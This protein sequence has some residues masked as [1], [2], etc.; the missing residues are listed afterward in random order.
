MK[1]INNQILIILLLIGVFVAFSSC[2]KDPQGG[3]PTINSISLRF[4]P[5]DITA[6]H[7]ADSV[8]TGG[9]IQPGSWIVINGSN[10]DMV[11]LLLV[12]NMV[13]P[14]NPTYVTSNNLIVQIPSDVPTIATDP[15]VPNTLVV[16]T[17]EGSASTSLTMQPPRPQILSIDNE[18]ALPGKTITITG[19]YF[20]YVSS[21]VFPGNKSGTHVSVL[22]PNTLTVTVPDGIPDTGGDIIITTMGGTSITRN[23]A[24]F[25]ETKGIFAGFEQG[26]DNDFADWGYSYGIKEISSSTVNPPVPLINGG[27]MEMTNFDGTNWQTIPA[28]MWW[29]GNFECVIIPD[30]TSVLADIPAST[31]KSNLAFKFEFYSKE[32]WNSGGY[33]IDFND[34]WDYETRMIYWPYFDPDLTKRKP[35]KT[36]D[37]V[38]VTI[39]LT[40]FYST[41]VS[42]LDDLIGS[43]LHWFYWNWDPAGTEGSGIGNM[44]QGK[45]YIGVPVAKFDV[46]FDNL[47]IVRM[48]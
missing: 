7:E 25:H 9:S 11:N 12:N 46:F 42:T 8:I 23:G 35:L 15:D 24:R 22:N 5:S 1:T 18:F 31:S 13:V 29:D 34:N 47:R 26:M 6:G 14:F 41:R 30:Y 33:T 3:L 17:P 48:Q 2:S 37:W 21:V 43:E 40:D 45:N 28:S 27:Y 38:T 44:L 36:S 16:E 19:N 10:L 20:Y 32:N 4:L 39:P